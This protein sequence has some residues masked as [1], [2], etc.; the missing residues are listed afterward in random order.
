M[1]HHQSTIDAQ[2]ADAGKENKTDWKKQ[3]GKSAESAVRSL[4]I[5]SEG[6]PYVGIV[7][8]SIN[9]IIN[10][11]D[12]CKCNRKSFLKLRGRLIFLSE[13]L[14]EK[15]GLL[16]IAEQHSDKIILTSFTTRM[17]AV[18]NDAIAHLGT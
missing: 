9:S 4:L 5:I 13:L 15:G 16:E 11:C 6:L 17:L 1:S 3:V 7:A 14:F 12:Q 8:K 2:I 10:I 18:I